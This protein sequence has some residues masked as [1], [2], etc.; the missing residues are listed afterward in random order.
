M[1]K[2]FLLIAF[3]TFLFQV[4]AQQDVVPNANTSTGGGGS[5]LGPLYGSPRSYQYIINENQ[6]TNLIG[7]EITGISFRLLPAA[8][9][10]W[11]ATTVN[12]SNYDIYLGSGVAPADR[13]TTWANNVVG[14]QT[15]VRSG[16]LDIP[17]ASFPS[18]GN[19][20]NFG[21]PIDF[22]VPY[23][24]SGGHLLVEI[25]HSAITTGAQTSVEALG[26][27]AAGYGTDYAMYYQ[28]TYTPAGAST[29]GNFSV[30][31]LIS[32]ALSACTSPPNAGVAVSNKTNVCAG[33]NFSLNI[34]GNT[35]VS[36]KIYQ[37]QSSLTGNAPW[38]DVG[39][40]SS[41]PS[42]SLNHTTTTFYRA[43][44]TCN[45][46]TTYSDSVKVTTPALVSGTYTINPS[47]PTGTG[48]FANFEEALDFIKC[49]INGPVVFN[50]ENGSYPINQIIIPSI[51]GT[52]ATNTIT[53]N[54]NGTTLTYN[55]STS[56]LR[57][58]VVL[59]GADHIIIDSFNLDVGAGSHGWGIQLIN[60]ADNNIIRKCTII[61]NTSSTSSNYSGIIISGSL[62]GA[63]TAGNNG[64]GN[65]IEKNKIVGGYYG[66]SINGASATPNENNVVLNNTIEDFYGYGI[67]ASYQKSGVIKNNDLSRLT[68]TSALSSGA[69]IYITTGCVGLAVDGNSLHNFFTASTTNTTAFYGIYDGAD[70]TAAEPNRF[71]NNLIYGI[72]GDGTF[73]GIYNTGAAYMH[74]Y[75]NTISL[76]YTA[77]TG[78]T[79]YG[80]FQT[81]SDNGIEFRN[82]IIYIT[83]GGTGAKY[84]IYKSTAAT[85]LVSNNNVFYLNSSGS[86]AQNVGYQGS[87]QPTLSDWQTIS[88][89]DANSVVTDPLFTTLGIDYTPTEPTINDIAPAIGVAHDIIN[90]TR[91]SNPDPG[92]YEF[93]LPG[94]TNPPT[95]GDVVPSAN[96][97]CAGELFSLDLTGHSVGN[98]ILY[99]WQS[100]PDGNAPWT[101]IATPQTTTQLSGISQTATTWYRAG[102]QCNGGT[103]VYNTVP[104]QIIRPSL[105]SGNFTINNNLSTGGSNFQSFTEAVN[106]IKCGINGPV[107][108]NVAQGS[109]PY[110]EQVI[111]PEIL[112]TSSVNTITFNGNG[113]TLSYLSTSSTERA[114]L[115]LNGADYVIIDSL[116]IIAAGTTTSE[117]GYGI[118]L[119][120][121]ADN[122]IIRK[123]IININTT[124]T[125]TANYAGIVINST[126]APANVVTTKGESLC[127]NNSIENNTVIGGYAGI[128]VT[129]ND[130]VSVVAGIVIRNNIVQDF[131]EYG[132]T[133][134]GSMN[135]LIE[136]NDI[137]RPTR[138]SVST[139]RGI[140]LYNLSQKT[141]INK[142][143]IHTP[144]GA[145][146]SNT[147]AA[148]GIY[149]T[150][151][152]ATVGNENI[153]SNNMIYN[154]ANGAT[155]NPN[156]NGALI[157]ST[158]NLKFYHNSILLDDVSSTC[159]T[160][161]TRGMY[162]QTAPFTGLEFKNNIVKI[163]RGG[164]GPKQAIYF[165]GT[166]V[167]FTSD[168]NDFYIESTGG[169]VQTGYA[170]GTGYNSLTDWQT[171]TGQDQN[172]VSVDP[173][174]VSS[175]DLH[176]QPSSPLDDLGTSVAA[177]TEDIDGEA[178]SLS[179]PDIGADELPLIAGTDMK[180][181]ALISIGQSPAGCYN[182]ET[183][184]VR[185]KNNSIDPINFSTNPLTVTVNVTGPVTANY[186]ATVNTGTLASGATQDVTMNSPATL[187]MTS[188]GVY[189]FTITTS[190]S[191]DANP[192]NNVLT[193]Q[194]EKI[195]LS[196]GI[197]AS[198][199]DS[200]C[201]TGGTPTLSATDVQGY[202]ALKW[203]HSST[204][205]TG[206]TDIPGAVSNPY[207]LSTAITQT[208]YYRLVA[209]CGTN[210]APSAEVA[211]VLNNPQITSTTPGYTCGTGTVNLS[212][213]GTGI[214]IN[215][216]TDATGGTAIA[217]GNNFTT[218]VISNTTTY[219][220]AA[221]TGGSTVNTAKLAPDP[222]AT[223]TT[224]STY[225]SIFTLTEPIT[226]N[227]L[228]VFSGTG[229]AITISLYNAD[230][231][232]TA[233]MTTGSQAVTAGSSPIINLGWNI[234]PGTYR[235]VATMTGSFLRDGITTP[236]VVYPIAIGNAGYISGYSSSLTGALT[237]GAAYYFLYNWSV[238][239]G[240]ES[241]RVAV[242]ATVN[243]DPGCTLP[244]TLLSFTGKKEGTLNLLQWQT[245][246]EINNAGFALE[247]SADGTRFS[248]IAFVNSKA[249]QG[250]ST[251][252]LDYNYTDARPLAGNNYYRLKQ[253]DKDG[254]VNYS[255]IV[256][257]KG[258]K[259]NGVFIS[260]LY[261][262]PA[263]NE[264]NVRIESSVAKRVTLVVTD[265]S[266]R[267]LMKRN[268]QLQ[269]GTTLVS[270]ITSQL[271]QGSYLMKVIC[272]DGCES[273]VMKFMKQ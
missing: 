189:S 93:S 61:T 177:V 21:T 172:S 222:S 178:R 111:I 133:I 5:F 235:I 183:V 98:G 46:N 229:T 261:P 186:T 144:F 204:A 149:T 153:V 130:G 124:S 97:V 32:Q 210:E 150:A 267:I 16:N 108:F 258:E 12:Y 268:E 167:S 99:Y 78:G 62:T 136:G 29:G 134:N 33:E 156:H 81:T 51:Y 145:S 119:L 203:Q 265:I 74:A 132:I 218:P 162:M 125:S 180:P 24:Y 223:A 115:K 79:T 148:F 190:V 60:Q 242:T 220:V 202:S 48:N 209:V 226:L 76:D 1:K 86:G 179:T 232:G 248:S 11:P 75:H 128:S 116:T 181:E 20:N 105:V 38:S 219:Y 257:L 255:N 155:G 193:L 213:A 166:G 234:Q 197:A 85:P 120:N 169:T 95:A 84:G 238:T 146:S 188:L 273:P 253:T 43:A 270:V 127:D 87:A 55:T 30:I 271:V 259:V 205:G 14:G 42:L 191:G 240:C 142:N 118:Q 104:I 59:D 44:V 159:T 249:E 64:S 6:L 28:S 221:S 138:T 250:N 241:N 7:R 158:D 217:S 52:S 246:S 72:E 129:A 239:T 3:C 121:D 196:G 192:A 207:T 231:S 112:G 212:A 92:A 152:R 174:F 36:G 39:T 225:P 264:V 200:Y 228:Q 272:D 173:M 251:A 37:W 82:N 137:S 216:Y 113:A 135:G 2:F 164:T 8:S 143:K 163:S 67:Y 140:S 194:R 57:S 157:V 208:T 237:S 269:S 243:N 23:L 41:L 141:L 107:V 34:S 110:T 45:G 15:Q 18:G 73:Y 262:N 182:V 88:G 50:V 176:L 27:S 114:V 91:G 65:L 40:S 206:F 139:F 80:F 58:A 214:E 233:L 53:F 147:S 184:A 252:L 168:N 160:C 198:S 35:L 96:T 54:G 19:P 31:Q 117:Y 90:A 224:L 66:I 9:T 266:G 165:E 211:V 201:I 199:R 122:N 247:R 195:G 63:T 123:C 256:L 25:R 244:V 109:G 230:G 151:C 4:N 187:N 89:Q 263:Q 70:G 49:G 131:Y 26:T 69:G 236:S 17:A 71:I 94:C 245:A 22:H 215:W 10:A 154:F 260:S 106:H 103:I 170:N 83:R 47:L 13:S 227:S 171:G 175:T 126:A 100:S 101:S 185:V 56:A 161:G 102:V 77:A 68:R 254:K